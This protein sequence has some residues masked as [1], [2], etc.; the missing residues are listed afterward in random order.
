VGKP[1]GNR[2]LGKPRRRWKDN[3]KA[4]LQGVGCGGMDWIE[5]AQYRYRWWAIVNAVMNLL[6]LDFKLSPCF[7]YCIC[8]FGY[9]HSVRLCLPDRGFRNVGKTQ[10]DAGQIPKRT[11][12]K[13]S[14]SIK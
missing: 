13:P 3:V 1:E 6:V 12:T 2:P 9:F 5:L 8:S 14:G 7:E 11:Y 4:D 10:S